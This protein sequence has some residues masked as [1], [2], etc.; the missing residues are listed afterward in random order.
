MLDRARIASELDALGWKCTA[1]A[2][3]R[4]TVEWS[5]IAFALR[6]GSY[7]QPRV[8]MAAC[9]VC[10]ATLRKL[11]WMVKTGADTPEGE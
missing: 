1:G 5:D 7:K 8:L 3:R 6:C 9:G 4:G 2:A 10:R 11:V